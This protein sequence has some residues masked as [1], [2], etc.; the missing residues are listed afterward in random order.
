MCK[1]FSFI[2]D[3]KGNFYYFNAEQRKNF[4]KNESNTFY[5]DS[6]S[7]IASFFN[8]DEDTCNK[9]EFQPLTKV[10]EIDQINTIN[11]SQKAKR[12]VKGL[13]FQKIVPELIIKNIVHP[14]NDVQRNT[15]DKKDIIL[16]KEWD[17]VRDSVRDS[18]RA[19]VWDS[20]RAS[21]WDSVWDSVGAYISSFFEIEYSYNFSSCVNL[22]EKGLVP[23]FDGTFWHLHGKDGKILYSISKT[24]LKSK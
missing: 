11:D 13:D 10:F 24:E 18:I 23:F 5:P 7:S 17:S 2:S 15:V 22:W 16:L 19:S 9:F 21:V 1:F 3:G 12:F 6:H 4:L 8:L 14:F 20:I